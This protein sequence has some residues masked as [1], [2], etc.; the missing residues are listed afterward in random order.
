MFANL[1]LR[2]SMSKFSKIWILLIQE[3]LEIIYFP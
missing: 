2:E 1:L 3:C